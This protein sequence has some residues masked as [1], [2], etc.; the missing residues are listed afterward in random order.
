MF[1]ID[2]IEP[3]FI[4]GHRRSGT[5]L[6][7]SLLDFHPQ[8]HVYP[9]ESKFFYLFYPKL[10]LA[11]ISREQKV[12]F[13]IEKNFAFFKDI[14]ATK[15][16]AVKGYIDEDRMEDEFRNYLNKIEEI[17]WQDY[18]KGMITAFAEVSY[19]DKGEIRRWVEKTTS[20]EIFAHEIVNAFPGARFIHI[21]RDPRDNY[22]S[23]KSGWE[24]RYSYLNDSS[25]ME[26]LRESCIM[27]GVLGMKIG[28]LNQQV[29]GTER[30]HILK[31]EDLVGAPEATLNKLANFLGID[32][33]K[34]LLN[35]TVCGLAWKGNN[36]EGKSF[37]RVS[38]TRVGKW[39]KR[40]NEHEAALMEF[41]FSNVMDHFGYKKVFSVA[42]QIA[43]ASRHYE[44]INFKSKRKA[45]YRMVTKA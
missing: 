4:C 29:F 12:E 33:D 19:Q 40:I 27:R 34:S 2:K 43:A 32:Y 3:T 45:D 8:L 17:E 41:H 37:D 39:T 31:Y 24:K 13:I 38:K 35:P 10:A 18:L 14:L 36:F 44:W 22:S 25:N 28:I 6:L 1:D 16:D 30:Y 9:D 11:D 42:E 5:T 15:T 7:V 20:S 26:D 23:L 21:V